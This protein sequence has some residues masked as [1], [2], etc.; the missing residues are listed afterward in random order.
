MSFGAWCEWPALF[1]FVPD[2]SIWGGAGDVGQLEVL[3]NG[4]VAFANATGF[5]SS[6]YST[7]KALGTAPLIPFSS[8]RLEVRYSDNYSTF[9]TDATIGSSQEEVVVYARDPIEYRTTLESIVG[10]TTDPENPGEWLTW[11]AQT[12]APG[13]VWP[14]QE[15]TDM[16]T[17]PPDGVTLPFAVSFPYPDA[18]T[19]PQTDW[20]MTQ[21]KF[22]CPPNTTCSTGFA[23]AA[24]A[25][26]GS[27]K[28]ISTFRR[29]V[30]SHEE[31][32]GDSFTDLT[33]F[34]KK[35]GHIDYGLVEGDVTDLG[36]SSYVDFAPK[37]GIILTLRA[38]GDEVAPPP[39]PPLL[40]TFAI[41]ANLTYPLSLDDG[42]AILDENVNTWNWDGADYAPYN[43][44]DRLKY[45]FSWEIPQATK[46]SALEGRSGTFKA[47][48]AQPIPIPNP[49]DQSGAP[50][51]CSPSD[52]QRDERCFFACS[53][54]TNVDM[55]DPSTWPDA[56]LPSIVVPS[57][58]GVDP[59][60][61]HEKD[62]CANIA[63]TIKGSALDGAS[64]Y[65]VPDPAKLADKL[66]ENLTPNDST[67]FHNFRC[68]FHPRY[69][70]GSFDYKDPVT[71]NKMTVGHPTCEVIVRAERLNVFPDKVEAVFFDGPDLNNVPSYE[72]HNEAFALFLALRNFSPNAVTQMCS[73]GAETNSGSDLVV[74]PF[75]HVLLR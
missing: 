73:R 43:I 52:K 33:G 18:S 39:L 71:G 48:Q 14:V 10:P 62:F 45:A 51:D 56:G 55:N 59:P 49:V 60:S 34:I 74:H 69:E 66:T 31:N 24:A 4:N 46:L 75:P 5:S 67:R 30:C 61:W 20:L 32:I 7:D 23:G 19:S 64:A 65:P 57:D 44:Q 40:N 58:I 6:F 38:A 22:V 2:A 29:G 41:D 17:V 72:F 47:G 37:G 25:F 12:F 63:K 36:L 21:D 26:G 15:T 27:I 50:I 16:V 8:A 42:I 54:T 35:Y 13:D 53:S 3:A 68:N 28:G 70:G 11:V 9:N 1:S